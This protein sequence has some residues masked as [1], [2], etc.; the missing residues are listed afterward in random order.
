MGALPTWVDG[1]I[2]LTSTPADG[3]GIAS[4]QYQYKL[5]SS[6]DVAEHLHAAGRRRTRARSTRRR[7]TDGVSYDF[8]VIATDNAGRTGTSAT[9]TSRADR[10]NP[11][12]TMTSP[13]PYLA[14]S[15]TLASTAADTGT[16]GV[17]SVQY[18][19]R[20]GAGPWT[21]ACSSSG[22]PFSCPF[23][24]A[25]VA[26]G[27]YSFQAIVTDNVGR[28][29]TS[30]TVTNR[31]IDNTNPVTSTIVVPAGA[32]LS[33]NLNF[34]GTAADNGGGS[35]VA[36]WK[37]QASPT[38]AG[39]WT[40]LCSD[41]ATPFNGCTGNVD[42]LADG[43]YD[44]R[45]VVTDN[46]GNTLASALVTNRRVDT[47]GPVA[48]VTTPANGTRVRGNV[49]LTA[50]AIDPAGVT[51]VQ[52]QVFY[53][54]GWLTFCTDYSPSYT[55]TGDS[56]QVPDG[57]Y[58]VRVVATDTLNHTSTSAATSLIIDNTGPNAT[59]IDSAS[60]GAQ[61]GRMDAGDT[62]TF[63]WN[64]AIAPASIM[65]GWNGTS[66][67]IQIRA[68][69][70]GTSDTIDFFTTGGGTHL[71]LTEGAL[72]DTNANYVTGT[73]NFN[74]TMVMSGNSITVTFGSQIGTGGLQNVTT[75]NPDLEWDSTN[76]TTDLIGNAAS[77]NAVTEAG[78]D[79]DF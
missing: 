31:Q 26:D 39:T 46:A 73:V 16:S 40:D 48:T 5:S 41:T 58:Q 27:I 13:A 53:L 4:V 47:D 35:G 75:G 57:T 24:T 52:F 50:A 49:T 11:T 64:E 29:A 12:V 56:T 20:L 44:F 67:A 63:T 42:G 74:G 6:R 25:S 2:T 38:G 10:T 3:G 21:N 7:M 65:T 59:G 78:N 23:N 61:D 8:R 30:A 1:T 68:I 28:T 19:Y 77:G 37:V 72:L 36:G 22:T 33:G 71:N 79:I 18:Q 14:G 66:Q 55:C 34:T 51:S 9:V 32:N 45:A 15:V 17:A 43:N 69:N 76:E 54:G 70:N 60:S 62:I